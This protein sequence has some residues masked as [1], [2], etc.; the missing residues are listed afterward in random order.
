M[1]LRLVQRSRHA[2]LGDDSLAAAD[3]PSAL[4]PFLP[5]V[6]QRMLLL[7]DAYLAAAGLL[8]LPAVRLEVLR[9]SL[10]WYEPPAAGRAEI[11]VP[12]LDRPASSF[13]P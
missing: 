8:R 10:F 5:E 2:D 13:P 7:R 3:M 6:T 11:S 4:D 1:R 9:K 12:P